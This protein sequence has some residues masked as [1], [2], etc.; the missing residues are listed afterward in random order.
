MKYLAKTESVA[1]PEGEDE[2]S[3]EKPGPGR[4][5][6]VWNKELLNIV[7]EKV[8]VSS[9][10]FFQIRRLLRKLVGLKPRGTVRAMRVFV[11]DDV[12]KKIL[13]LFSP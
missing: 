5:W 4:F 7:W 3:E 13:P 9:K 8:R 11:K 2:S 6:G 1:E 12:I 10:D